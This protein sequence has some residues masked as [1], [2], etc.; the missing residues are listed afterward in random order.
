[1]SF[2]KSSSDEP[3]I[4]QQIRVPEVRLINF[5]GEM[6]GVFSAAEAFRKA[7]D[8]GYDLVE[9]VPN[10]KPPVCKIMDY[11]KYK[12]E[13]QKKAHEARKKQK[14][15]VLKEIKIRPNIDEND[16]EIKI[17]NAKRFLE[18]GDK[19]K[20]SMRFRGREI[21]HKEIGLQVIERVKTTLA[22]DSRMEQD[23]RFEGMQVIMIL[24][25]K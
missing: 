10:A 24:A 23:A 9:I 16:L 12:Y 6:I 25:P 4:N 18:E 3:R 5:D 20:F 8:A 22:E 7:Q 1:M 2:Q 15:V 13:A 17:R 11:G 21:S 19:V 14:V